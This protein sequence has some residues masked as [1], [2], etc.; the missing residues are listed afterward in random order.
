[1]EA[2]QEF[3]I[4]KKG[5]LTKY[6][7]PG[8]DVVIPEGVKAIGERVFYGCKSLESVTIPEGVTE[9]GG[10]AFRGC[11]NLHKAAVPES[12][13]I[14]GRYAFCDCKS[15]EYLTI[16]GRVKEIGKFAF[17]GCYL[18]VLTVPNFPIS[19]LEMWDKEKAFQGF[20]KAYLENMEIDE[21]MEAGNLRY[22]KSQKKNLVTYSTIGDDDTLRFLFETGA[23][24][25]ADIKW[26]LQM[27]S[28]T[29]RRAETKE[30]IMEYKAR[31]LD[32]GAL[33]KKAAQPRKTAA[34]RK[35][36][37]INNNPDF[38]ISKGVLTEYKGPGGDVV[39]PEGVKEIA[40]Q[41]FTGC[42]GLAS[43]TI[44]ESVR[45][46]SHYAFGE[47]SL[48]SVTI[49]KSVQLIE[50][51]AFCECENLT[52]VTFQDREDAEGIKPDVFYNSPNITN[53][54]IPRC[55]ARIAFVL[56]EDTL[57]LKNLGEFAVLD[58]F[59]IK[60]QGIKA[61][62]VIPEG[63][64]EIGCGTF[65]NCANLQ[66]VTIPR[67]V[68][69]IDKSAFEGSRPVISA[70]HIPIDEFASENKPGACAGFAKAYLD[71][72]ELDEEIKADYLGYIK[73]Q[74]KKLYPAA[75]QYEEMLQL[76]FAGKMISRKDVDPL[77]EECEKQKNTA[78][79]AAVLDYA[80]R[81]LKPVD[82]FDEMEKELAK[83]ERQARRF[84]E[85]GQLPA[86]ELKKIWSTKKREDGTLEIT[87][88]KGTDATVSVPAVIGKTAVTAIGEKALSPLASRLTP[89]QKLVRE[90]LESVTIPEGV[91]EI[92]KSAFSGCTGLTDVAIAEGV[93]NIT[94]YTFS[95]TP[96]FKNLGEL[97][98]ANHILLKYRGNSGDVTIPE[99]VTKIGNGAFQGCTGLTSVTIPAGVTEIGVFA[100]YG[101]TGLISVTIPADVK[102]IGMD[103]FTHCPNLTIHA[104]AG[105]YAEA[106]AKKKK[107][108]FGAI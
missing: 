57:W 43:V 11:E 33:V 44:P 81:S 82:P 106:Y 97:A 34:P 55:V 80:G 40:C 108:K 72:V 10:F 70:P 107:I 102:E 8:G 56:F 59:L 77:L 68:E 35:K 62:V 36:T 37:P 63:I 64:T 78:A 25:P 9:I 52:S 49:P 46:I 69:E 26:M 14:I 16:P 92:D 22:I 32:S 23:V 5:V 38:D 90:A 96:W 74:K 99:G 3:V 39:I 83:A 93:T 13:K 103:A 1:M 47:S 79:K 76:M 60:Y 87:S 48:Q 15:L 71:G 19:K 30:K 95:D 18:K 28:V 24:K 105:S 21:E 89:E 29:L 73:G 6:N 54:A 91:T 66:S 104:P 58:H 61:N 101:C 94:H 67:S 12:V 20:V 65:Q 53:V 45:K 31:Y 7:G 41:A 50:S 4:T 84:E 85:T 2:K 17:N 27:A 51:D 88:Y 100:F 98:V 42:K 75:V 86:G